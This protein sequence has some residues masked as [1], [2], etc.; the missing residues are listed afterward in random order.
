MNKV[1]R[2][3]KRLA[4]EIE[5]REMIDRLTYF[6]E[7]KNDVPVFTEMNIGDRF[8]VLRFDHDGYFIF[9]GEL[10]KNKLFE[11]LATLAHELGHFMAIKFNWDGDYYKYLAAYESD[12]KYYEFEAW[13]F[14]MPLLSQV[15]FTYWD[16]L[17]DRIVL[18]HAKRY[19]SD[20]I[21]LG[22]FRR[23]LEDIIQKGPASFVS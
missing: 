4:L 11:V 1:Q 13:M 20:E 19:T 8:G 18:A 22:T 5:F 14:A 9:I 15:G 7:M 10:I 16:V 23:A 3:V 12:E 2:E 6:A 21:E 17:L